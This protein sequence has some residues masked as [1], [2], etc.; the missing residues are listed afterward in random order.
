M[1]FLHLSVLSW[2]PWGVSHHRGLL[3]RT[4]FLEYM[5]FGL[6]GLLNFGLLLGLQAAGSS[7]V[8][9]VLKLGLATARVKVR[10]GQDI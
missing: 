3:L 7:N 9:H 4:G 1:D 2:A 5:R 6:Q 8:G 10:Q